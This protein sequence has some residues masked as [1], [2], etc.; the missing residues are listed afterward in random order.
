M[1]L[2][3]KERGI[4]M[5]FVRRVASSILAFSLMTGITL[6]FAQNNA[7]QVKVSQADG[8]YTIGL[9]GA[10][11]YALRAG[12]GVQADGHWLHASDYPNHAVQQSR[13]QGELGSATDWQVTY[14]GLSGAPDL[15]YHLRA[16]ADEPFGDIQ[17]IVR[18]TTGRL[19]HIEDIRS[20]DAT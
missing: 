17:V 10:N 3:G 2:S 18:N 14:S 1:R 9:P 19:I 16:Y 6:A 4:V 15:I 13:V 20:V 5:H 11:V 8:K 12:V 7:L